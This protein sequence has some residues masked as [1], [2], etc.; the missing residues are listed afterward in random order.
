MTIVTPKDVLTL[1]AGAAGL[2]LGIF[3]N[4][5]YVFGPHR[6][7]AIQINGKKLPLQPMV[8]IRISKIIEETRVA[9]S[10]QD[11]NLRGA[12]VKE[13]MGIGEAR[14][15]IEGVLMS[16]D[17]TLSQGI[18]NMVGVSNPSETDAEDDWIEK[19]RDIRDNFAAEY[20]LPI[21]GVYDNQDY[22]HS[23]SNARSIF[24][25]LGIDMVVLRDLTIHDIRGAD[26]KGYRLKLIQDRP[27]EITK[28]LPTKE[29]EE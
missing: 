18:M 29:D 14:I 2:A 3:S 13:M 12:T 17:P 4:K 22:G 28:L 19:I 25:E 27:L 23:V 6:Y 1:E 7:G 20:A 16:T 15:D 11:E 9:G 8:T 5:D 24:Q 26:R 21:Q 10:P